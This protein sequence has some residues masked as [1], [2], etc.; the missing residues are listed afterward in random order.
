MKYWQIA[1]RWLLCAAFLGSTA[2]FAAEGEIEEIVVTGSYIQA[3]RARRK[4]RNCR[5]T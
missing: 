4:T 2:V 5:L 1:W 3:F